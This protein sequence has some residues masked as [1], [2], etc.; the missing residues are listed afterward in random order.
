MDRL[1][2]EKEVVFAKL[3][4]KGP[5]ILEFSN[6]CLMVHN[7]KL[8][9]ATPDVMEQYKAAQSTD[10]EEKRNRLARMIANLIDKEYYRN[11]NLEWYSLRE[12]IGHFDIDR[13][14]ELKE[15]MGYG[16]SI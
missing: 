10:D 15:K 11:R 6:D 14:A 7:G 2:H 16:K 12:Y 1:E 4:R 8:T 3:I 9:I 13:L 5:H